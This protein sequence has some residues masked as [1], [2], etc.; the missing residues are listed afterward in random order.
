MKSKIPF[1]NFKVVEHKV[2]RAGRELLILEAIFS[3]P[4]SRNSLSV[5]VARELNSLVKR[6]N[7]SHGLVVR[8]DGP[9]FCAGG[10]IKDHVVMGRA[11]SLK[12]NRL[13]AAACEGLA[14]VS[15]PT[16]AIVEGDVFGGGIEFLSCFDIVVATPHIVIGFWQRRLGLVYGWGGGARLERR[17][18]RQA[19]SRLGIQASAMTG[20]EAFDLGLIDRVVAPWQIRAEA[21]G[22]LVRI[23]ALPKKSVAVLKATAVRAGAGS[24]SRAGFEKLWFGPEHLDRMNAFVR[25]K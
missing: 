13:I 22:E 16:V 19:V 2:M 20:R 17:I 3:N 23:A 12:G 4:E 18:G 14:R 11:A 9:V 5:A 15:V 6:A 25:R 10:N 7:A 24:E 21:M 1:T 8:A